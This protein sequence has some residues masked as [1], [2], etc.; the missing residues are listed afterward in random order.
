MIDATATVTDSDSSNFNGGSLT[1]EFISISSLAD[2]L[3]I[4]NVG[5]GSGE[6]GVSGT[7]VTYGGVIIGT[8]AGGSYGIS[9][10]VSL[11]G[12]A[13]P[14]A[15]QELV[16]NATFSSAATDAETR[17]RYLQFTV[18]DDAGGN[19]SNQPF[20]VV[21][22]DTATG[23]V[24]VSLSGSDLLVEGADTD[25]DLTLS[26]SGT[27]LVITDSI[28][29]ITTGI[30]GATGDGT[31]TVIVPLSALS[32]NVLV[33]TFAGADTI[34]FDSTFNIGTTRG[35]ILDGS[36]NTV[37]WNATATLASLDVTAE[38]IHLNSGAVTTT[39]DQTYSGSIVLGA[40]TIMTGVNMTFDATIDSDA[41]ARDLT[42]NASGAVEFNGI[43]GG[44]AV[45]NSIKVDSTGGTVDINAA[46]NV[47][48]G[49]RDIDPPN[50]VNVSGPINS[51]GDVNLEANVTVTFVNANADV[52]TTGTATVDVTAGRKIV[53]NS[54]SSITT[55]DGAIALQA[56][57]DGSATG[58]FRGID[59]NNADIT[60]STGAI[61]LTATGGD[62]GDENFGI[63]LQNGS[64]ISSSGT[65]A[66]SI[67]LN[68]TG[69]SGSSN[70]HGVFIRDSGSH[71]AALS[72]AIEINGTGG[73]SSNAHGVF[74][75]DSGSYVA[76]DSGGIEITG[77][78]ASGQG[79]RVGGGAMVTTTGS[80]IDVTGSTVGGSAGIRVT[81]IDAA[82]DVTLTALTGVI[83][84]DSAGTD[85]T[86]N[87]VT[88]NGELAPGASQRNQMI[89]DGNLTFSSTD[90]Y[91]V[92]LRGLTA[93]VNYDQVQITGTG[94]N[95]KVD[96]SELNVNLDSFIPSAGDDFVI[97]GNVDAGSGV[98]GTFAGLADG[99]SFTVSG[100]V[101]H[102]FYSAGMD[103]NDVV[104]VVNR[105]P[106]TPIDSDGAAN[107]VDEG[108]ATGTSVGLTA[109][110]TD[111][112]GDTVHVQPDQ[113]RRRTVRHRFQHRRGD[114][115]Q[116]RAAGRAGD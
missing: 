113:R 59:L 56:N 94:R 79:V 72:G 88:I 49:G 97:I 36:A 99:D 40:G 55:A 58:T 68:G 13:T 85:V 73:S 6:I 26:V 106:T 62:S 83:R 31:N 1:V 104:L 102:I 19:T 84:E 9:L 15:V 66:G 105:P 116:R 45:P 23:D 67:T 100:T 101:F 18:L 69:G 89:F 53:M 76:A 48:A 108:A 92:Q 52:T 64:A 60:S 22:D 33:T 2:V 44:T 112:D 87:T 51:A 39:G 25:D 57:A 21:V 95:V 107:A 11:N 3:G 34:T 61:A 30:T 71:V 17:A 90:K 98:I 70:A 35:V 12:N 27:V 7:D 47:G 38:T 77:V 5:T 109:F 63:L 29:V 37:K 93:G 80:N 91:T 65:G 32:G 28:N 24:S 96:N 110:A 10:T 41:T 54:G 111:P 103:N 50:F 75:R 74:I 8:L 20:A 81:G 14:A 16:R 42:V 115:R 43:V 114:H 78:G 82:G 4:R 86:G 46:I